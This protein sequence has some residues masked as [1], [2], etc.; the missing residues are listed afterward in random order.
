MNNNNN[1]ALSAA[2]EPYLLKAFKLLHSKEKNSAEKLKAMLDE[3]CL[4]SNKNGILTNPT[5]TF[6]AL[7]QGCSNKLTLFAKQKV[8]TLK[9]HTHH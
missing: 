5:P 4:R 2:V 6:L 8:K 3:A 7:H 9:F 1:N